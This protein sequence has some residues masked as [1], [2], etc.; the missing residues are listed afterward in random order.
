MTS[1]VAF[2]FLKVQH[3]RIKEGE[4]F[5]LLFL[6]LT[7]VK[8]REK[9]IGACHKYVRHKFILTFTCTGVL[10]NF[11]RLGRN[12]LT[13]NIH[14]Y[15]FNLALYQVQQVNKHINTHRDILYCNQNLLKKKIDVMLCPA[16][17]RNV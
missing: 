1:Q 6:C 9:K 2:I 3:I 13:L 11:N 17:R 5:L 16:Q 12:L 10:L 7:T 14:L 15:K 8:I 4:I